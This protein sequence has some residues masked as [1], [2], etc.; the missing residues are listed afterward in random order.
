MDYS[1]RIAGWKM[2]DKRIWAYD[3]KGSAKGRTI[4]E[5][6]YHFLNDTT[7]TLG[8]AH[9]PYV[10]VIPRSTSTQLKSMKGTSTTPIM[11]TQQ[12]LIPLT[13]QTS[14]SLWVDSL[15]RLSQLLVNDL[16]ST[17][18]G[19]HYSLTSL[20]FSS[21][22]DPDI[23]YSKTS[24]V[25]LVMTAAK[26]SRQ[27]L[28]FSPTWGISWSGKFLT[29]KTSAFPKTASG[30]SLSDILEENVDDKYFLS[31]EASSKILNLATMSNKERKSSLRHAT[32]G[33]TV[34]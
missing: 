12:Q 22:K 7:D 18:L 25:Y 6:V 20:G 2:N 33:K 34:A 19:V 5:H 3:Q 8:T 31:A 21:T 23:W 29:A 1:K 9:V 16:D 24:K 27:S 28:G 4:Q 10:L 17:K 15:A 26:L 32:S 14:T 11:E 30:C 13:S